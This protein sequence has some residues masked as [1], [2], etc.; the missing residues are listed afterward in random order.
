LI[1]LALIEHRLRKRI[2]DTMRSG[3]QIKANKIKS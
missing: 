3:A 2:I 1:L